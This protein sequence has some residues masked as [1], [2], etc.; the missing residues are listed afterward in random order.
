MK[1]LFFFL[2]L[3]AITPFQSNAQRNFKPGYIVTLEGDT[4]KGFIDYKE[5]NQNPRDITFKT[6]EQAASQ[7]YSPNKIKAFGVYQLDSYQRYNG[8]I[9]KGAVDLADLSSGID[10][11]YVTDTV[12]LRVVSGGKNVTLYSYRDKIKTRFFIADGKLPPAELR[13]YVYLDNTQANKIREFNFYT[14]QLL[15]LAI[16]YAPNN[17]V[18]TASINSA[19]Y[20]AQYLE[21]VILQL[22]G[23]TNNYKFKNEDGGGNSQFFIGIGAS[24]ANASFFGVEKTNYLENIFT[25]KT[26]L[27]SVVPIIAGGMDFYINK[28][29]KKLFFR[30]ELNLTMYKGH[31]TYKSS[32]MDYINKVD[33]EEELTFNQTAVAFNPQFV[34][35]LYN[36]NSFKFFVAGG[37]QLTFS[38]FNNTHYYGQNFLNGK[39]ESKT[40]YPVFYRTM[41]TNVTAKTGVTLANKFD[42]YLGYC[43]PVTI[44]DYPNYG[45]DMS[46]YR[47]GINYLIS[48]K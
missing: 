19:S 10:S 47:L 1:Y 25:A 20:R 14:Q 9:T 44:T 31:A 48:K 16:K 30:A 45:I 37:L 17:A 29:V 13:R 42:I 23:N 36:A 5:W 38:L 4:T 15:A 32:Y 27:Q 3:A 7:Q 24:L 21:A 22:N 43:A 28:N 8:P 33:R 39:P 26:R 41:T 46:V 40:D 2:L 35:N 18:L 12:F 34:Y 6:T 11:S